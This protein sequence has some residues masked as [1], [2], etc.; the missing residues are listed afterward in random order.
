MGVLWV[1]AVRSLKRKHDW[2][3][4]KPVERTTECAKCIESMSEEYW[5]LPFSVYFSILGGDEGN[6]A[7]LTL[8]GIDRKRKSVDK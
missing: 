5:Q 3:W 2:D 6:Y 4:M 8:F 7:Y 1:E